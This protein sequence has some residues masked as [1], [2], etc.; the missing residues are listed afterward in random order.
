MKKCEGQCGKTKEAWQFYRT[1]Y[2]TLGKRCSDCTKEIANKRYHEKKG[3]LNGETNGPS[4]GITA[5]GQA[6]TGPGREL[7]SRSTLGANERERA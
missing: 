3:I 2:G 4:F 6:E 7:L 1:A 5:N